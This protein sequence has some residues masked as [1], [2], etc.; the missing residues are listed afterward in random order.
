M[1]EQ[2]QQQQQY[3]YPKTVDSTRL[4]WQDD[5]ETG[6]ANGLPPQPLKRSMS[7]SSQISALSVRSVARRGTVDP[8][9]TLPIHYRTV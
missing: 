9:T 4:Q 3:I 6:E 1:T 5:E 7:H 2:Q 8:A